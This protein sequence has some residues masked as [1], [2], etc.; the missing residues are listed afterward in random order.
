MHFHLNYRGSLP[1]NGTP[2]QKHCLRMHFHEQLKHLW[3]QKPLS[4]HRQIWN[5][6][7][8]RTSGSS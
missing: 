7:T 4:A 1:S 6:P 2:K 3:S 8:R 5:L